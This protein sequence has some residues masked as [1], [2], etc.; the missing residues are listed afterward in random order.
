[1]SVIKK[2]LIH[3]LPGPLYHIGLQKYAGLSMEYTG[4]IIT[5]S[6]RENVLTQKEVCGFKFNCMKR[7]GISFLLN[8]K[9]FFFCIKFSLKTRLAKN[10]YDFVLTYD[11][12]KTGLFGVVVS[13]IIGCKLIVE[14]N[15]VYT[16]DAEY[17]DGAEYLSVK[18]KKMLYPLIEGFVL[19]RASGIKLLFDKQIDPFKPRIHGKVIRSFPNLV[20]LDNFLKLPINC[21]KK[22]I[23]FVGFPFKRKGVDV[24][25]EAFKR[26][27]DQ[28]PDWKLRILGWFPDPTELIECIGDH[29]QIEYHPPVEYQD[30][31]G[32]LS[33][34]SILVLPSRSEAMGRI[35][36]E[37]MAAGKSRIG[38]D[39]D[40]IPTVISHNEDGLLFR[41]ED[42]D[43]LSSKLRLLMDDELIR[44]KLGKNGRKRVIEKMSK[45]VYFE[46]LF[47]FYNEVIS[48]TSSKEDR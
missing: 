9:F 21:S 22:Q 36:L 18:I 23:L 8:I 30:M 42:V 6:N 48:K 43:D 3:I 29:S 14:V 39:I 38:A 4:D 35:L 20:E 25:I 16:S 41:P 2:K 34:C 37:A 12:L 24:L 44:V 26:V 17:L 33:Q 13:K 19:K 7:T 31:P 45:D 10:R 47:D 40:G 5:S 11:P 1:M 46:R 15:G 32:L 28:F 27:S